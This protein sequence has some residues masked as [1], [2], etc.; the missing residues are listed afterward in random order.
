MATLREINM[1]REFIRM[2]D[3][4]KKVSFLAVLIENDTADIGDEHSW[5]VSSDEYQKQRY[6]Y[7]TFI[8]WQGMHPS[9]QF[10]DVSTFNTMEKTFDNKTDAEIW[11]NTRIDDFKP[12][13]N[14]I[15]GA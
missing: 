5:D 13:I 2:I 1:K 3:G 9:G 10:E 12:M 6:E 11:Y 14:K 8:H 15:T 7:K 4:H